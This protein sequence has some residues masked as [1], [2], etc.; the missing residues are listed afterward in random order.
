MLSVNLSTGAVQSIRGPRFITSAH[1]N[2]TASLSLYKPIF[3]QR[4][5][6]S[7][8]NFNMLSNALCLFALVAAASAVSCLQC[9]GV[10]KPH[11]R[12]CVQMVQICFDLIKN[13]TFYSAATSMDT[14]TFPLPVDTS[15]MISLAPHTSEL[16]E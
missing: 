5:Y 11:L 2:N 14:L 4:K 1:I 15:G 7:S 6:Q 9:L 16:V 3:F 8:H 12:G 13:I 10:L